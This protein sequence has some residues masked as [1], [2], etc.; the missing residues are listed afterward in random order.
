MCGLGS[1]VW[2]AGSPGDRETEAHMLCASS[3]LQQLCLHLKC[4][5]QPL[6]QASP[7]LP[8]LRDGA[9]PEFSPPWREG[10]EVQRR[11][12]ISARPPRLPWPAPHTPSRSGPRTTAHTRACLGGAAT[13]WQER[14]A[15]STQ[16]TSEGQARTGP[17]RPLCPLENPPLGTSLLPTAP[18]SCSCWGHPNLSLPCGSACCPEPPL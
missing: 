9:G 5:G 13:R 10:M 16:P 12:R 11:D 3:Y 1:R 18:Q 15:P 2:R 14:R 4:Y 6:G 17:L 8:A 7:V